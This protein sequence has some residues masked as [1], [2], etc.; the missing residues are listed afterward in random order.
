MTLRSTHA[1]SAP[2]PVERQVQFLAIVRHQRQAEQ[3]PAPAIIFGVEEVPQCGCAAAQLSVGS[4]LPLRQRSSARRSWRPRSSS[5]LADL[6]AA[7]LVGFGL[8]GGRRVDAGRRDLHRQGDDID[9]GLGD[10]PD[11]AG[12]QRAAAR[13]MNR[14][15]MPHPRLPQSTLATSKRR[16]EAPHQIVGADRHRRLLAALLGPAAGPAVPAGV[17]QAQ[18]DRRAA[19]LSPDAGRNARPRRSA[20]ASPGGSARSSCHPFRLV[21]GTEVKSTW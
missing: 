20:R 14:L 18:F 15:R 12:K 3:R 21:A 5:C 9:R 8:A 7:L 17:G 2:V 4:G 10:G 6:A 13:M 1:S 19:R 11:A 16:K